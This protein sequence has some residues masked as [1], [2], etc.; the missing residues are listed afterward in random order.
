MTIS[1]PVPPY[2]LKLSTQN[3]EAITPGVRLKII[4]NARSEGWR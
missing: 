2:T 3:I 4:R 1:T